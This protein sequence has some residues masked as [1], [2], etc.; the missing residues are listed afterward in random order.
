M[1]MFGKCVLR[2]EIVLRN[3]VFILSFSRVSAQTAGPSSMPLGSNL[4]RPR[5]AQLVSRAAA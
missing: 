5:P 3:I 2:Q 1:C 4:G